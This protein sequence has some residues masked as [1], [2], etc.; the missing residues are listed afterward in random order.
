[1]NN[2][3]S[4]KTKPVAL[5]ID[6]EISICQ[7]LAGIFSDEGW[8]AGY[9]ISGHE[10]IQAFKKSPPDL[11]LLDVWMPG[12]DGIETL[13]RLKQLRDDIPIVIMSGHGTI[14]TAVKCTKLGA[15]DFLEKPLSMEKLLPMI[16]HALQFRDLRN[17]ARPSDAG[18]VSVFVSDGSV[19][20]KRGVETAFRGVAA[21]TENIRRTIATIAPRNSWVLITGENG[22][23]KEVVARAVHN[24]SPRAVKA[25]VA[26]NCAAIPE[27]L[28][29]SELFGHARGA[30]TGAFAEKKGKF[31]LAHGGTLFLDEIGDMSLRTQAKILRILQEQRFE[32]LGDNRTLEV[33]VRVVAATNK[34]LAA[35]MK[36]GRF[37]EDLYHR[38][39]VIPVYVAPLRERRED[40][41]FLADFFLDQLSFELKEPRKSLTDEA[42]EVLM[43][44]PWPGNVRELKNLLERLCIIVFGQEI[45]VIDLPESMVRHV[46]SESPVGRFAQDSGAV[47]GT[48][49]G[50][51]S[52]DTAAG[53]N[54]RQA[55]MDFERS[56][57]MDRL[58]ENQWN[59]TKTAEAIGIERSH[60][61]KKLKIWGIDMKKVKLES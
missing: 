58:N 54:L 28:I 48:V 11:V 50:E 14:D 8:T 44:Y 30:Y 7:T 25:F 19:S 3:N 24:G 9:A 55:K 16:E 46:E 59:I 26:V 32:R 17:G 45:D 18:A 29:E 56:F 21:A 13:Q 49:L 37:R 39:N 4:S 33:D 52:G 47:L 20:V 34:D 57:V 36:A 40:I 22:T 2:V 60:L 43:H 23:G 10:G 5:I 38:L 53:G 6:D 31:E 35:E 12:L 41:P 61:H 42:F 15:F 1:M 27:D 51:G